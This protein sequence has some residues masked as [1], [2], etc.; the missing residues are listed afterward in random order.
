MIENKIE[1]LSDKDHIIKRPGMYIGS[2]ALEPHEKFHFGEYKS[3]EFVPGLIK[4]VDEIIDNSIDEAIR[5]NFEFANEISVLANQNTIKVSDNGRGIPQSDVVTPE[6]ETIPGPVA[7]WTRTK[8]GGNFGNDA[9]RKTG[10][11]N[12][13]G[14]ALTN[15]FS[16]SFTGTTCD[17]K[18]KIIVR[19]Q[20]G[21]DEVSWNKLKSKQNGTTVEFTPDF[22]HF[23]ANSFSPIDLEIIKYRLAT[24]AVVYPK[25][26]FTFN[27]VE[28]KGSFKEFCTEFDDKAVVLESE[29]CSLGIGRSPDGFRHLSY[30]NG[31]NTVNGGTHVEYV[32]EELASRL[33]EQFK[34]KHG[35][36]VTKSRIKE[37]LTV[38]LMIRDMSNLRFDSQTKERLS[39]P[40]GDVK[41]AIDFNFDK[42]TKNFLA[43]E[44]LVNPIIEA[45][46]VRKLAA[47]KAAETKALK[48]AQKATIPKHVSPTNYGKIGTGTQ[49]FLAEGDSAIGFL[50]TTRDKSKHGGMP[51][52]GKVV[53]TWGVTPSKQ[54]ENKEIFEIVS[55]LG[56]EYGRDVT[57]NK[58]Y[59]LNYDFINIFCD[60]DYDGRGSIYPSILSFLSQWPGLFKLG[61]VRWVKT[62]III[63][64]KDEDEYTDTKWFYSMEEYESD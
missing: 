30:A 42:I 10:G 58:D 54:L 17:G 51:L 63:A 50:M 45:A 57:S 40:N 8:A 56:L 41:K 1:M 3:I 49:L 61:R 24:L 11:Q 53:T 60:N 6:G 43:C 22:S 31:I 7:A 36:E 5:T 25:I 23:E 48:K 46:L 16:T 19:C 39:S 34:K 21:N 20:N 64:S 26:S 62:P 18:N 37:C 13:V 33:I 52:R 14:S 15:I 55:I 59:Y 47:E 4:L 38:V 35:I 9:D 27:G 28:I 2:V 29:T 32:I 12:G 44:D